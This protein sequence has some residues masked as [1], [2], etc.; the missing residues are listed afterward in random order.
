MGS[1]KKDSSA[2]V[3]APLENGQPLST[4]PRDGTMFLSWS[5]VFKVVQPTVRRVRF[6]VDKEGSLQT[7]DLGAWLFV[8]GVDDDCAERDTTGEISWSIAADHLN[9]GVARLWAPMPTVAHTPHLLASRG[10][11]RTPPPK[12]K[13]VKT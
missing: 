4:A 3:A 13:K 10:E 5:P 7:V 9:K 1:R 11:A 8:D 2:A 6:V 12:P